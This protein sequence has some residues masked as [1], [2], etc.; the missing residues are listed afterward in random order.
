MSCY[1]VEGMRLAGQSDNV[2]LATQLSR[3]LNECSTDSG[4]QRDLTFVI[5]LSVF[6]A[7][8]FLCLTV[9]S[10]LLQFVSWSP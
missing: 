8:Y 3:R 6:C 7:L 10:L 1:Q 9:N 4:V 2:A 5:D